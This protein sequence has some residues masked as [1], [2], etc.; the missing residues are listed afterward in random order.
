MTCAACQSFLQKTLEEQPGVESATVSLLLNNATVEFH[1]ETTSPAALVHAINATGYEA[2]LPNAVTSAFEQQKEFDNEAAAEYRS[3]RTKAIVA[4]VAGCAAMLASMPLMHEAATA[5]HSGM[6][7]PLMAW[8]TRVLDPV[9]A[10]A[11][12]WLY[13]IPVGFLSVGLLVLTS[14]VM[15]WTGGRFYIKAWSAA[16]HK[17]ADMNT[18]IAL[19]T[20]SAF[21][22][23]AAATVLPG[24]FHA[25]G[26]AADVY[27]EA[28]IWIIALI[29][30]G[31]ALE[32]RAKQRTADALRKLVQLQPQTARV[33]RG[34]RE[35]EIPIS[36]LRPLDIVVIRPGD[37][38]PS[39]GLVATGASSV[40]ESMLTGES[41]PVEKVVGDRVIGGTINTNGAFRY[42]V[43]ALGTD[44]VLAGIVR[45]LRDA[46][47]SRAPIQNL[48]DWISAIFVP[49]VVAIAIATALTWILSGGG[50]AR[51]FSAAVSVLIIA[52]PCA[53]GLA[54]PAA[55]MVATGRGASAGLLFK[56]GE[57]L[58]RLE[59][60]DTVV[61]DKTGTITEGKPTLRS[62]RVGPP[63]DEREVLRLAASVEQASEHPLAGAVVEAAR[64]RGLVLGDPVGFRSNAGQGVEALVENRQIAAG[65][66]SFLRGKGIGVVEE[67]GSAS[68]LVA[69]DGQF[70][71]AIEVADA[72]K[73]ASR[74]AIENLRAKGLRVILLSGDNPQMAKT[75]AKEAGIAEVIAGVLPAG[76]VAAIRDLQKQ[77][78]VVLMAGDGVNDAPAIAQADIGVAMASGSDVT[79]EAGDLTLMRNDLRGIAQAIELSRSTMRV[80]RQNLFWAFA[81]NAISIPVAAG[82]LYPVF[83]ILLSPILASAA[84]ALSSVSVVTNSLRLRHL[85]LE[86]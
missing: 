66:A 44:S 37:R 20:G 67:V 65:T 53:M 75:A 29:L 51:A 80:I 52:C 71:A 62:I 15:V 23:S 49:V 22:F 25:R 41:L 11:L 9:L 59:S 6:A 38:L 58:Q 27:Y 13:R 56:G 36:E 35:A 45:L 12:P 50:V 7:D 78:R 19:G 32:A 68:V 14:I 31:N 55:V 16:L 42:K 2:A 57:A 81:Y 48:A 60:I 8:Q 18:L 79:L 54:V 74:T 70:A 76:K 84:M 24:L 34:G 63:F 72:L 26:V 86:N 43:S 82:A 33:E 5:G 17:T 73:P 3:L 4:F 40:D 83:G 77:G 1:P 47:G 28:V 30:A 46:Q 69:I 21:V 85:R 10:S 39:D 64:S 61:F